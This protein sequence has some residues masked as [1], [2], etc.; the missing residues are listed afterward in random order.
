MDNFEIIVLLISV[1]TL[2]VGVAQK[3]HIPYPIALVIG[4]LAIG[5]IPR[6]EGFTVDPYLIL[7]IVLP[8]ILYYGAYQLPFREFIQNWKD[9]FSLAL[10]LVIVTT[11]VVGVVV[12]W[13]IP[14]FSWPL[15]FALGAI[16]S[17]PDAIA[18]TSILRRFAISNHT[19]TILE[20]ESLVNDASALVFYRIAVFAI[21]SGTFSLLDA[22]ISFVIMSTGGV[23]VGVITGL[24]MQYFS[25]RYLAPVVGVLFSFTIPYSTYFLA[26][27]LGLSGVLAV[28]V[29]GLIGARMLVVHPSPQR[30]VF[31]ITVWDVFIIMLNCFVF[32]LIGMQLGAVTKYMSYMRL[33]EYFL[34]GCAITLV[35]IVVRFIWVYLNRAIAYWYTKYYR[36]R[37][38]PH[39]HL[40]L[41]EA[42]VIGWSGM[43]GIVSLVAA[44]GLPLAH[45]NGMP[46]VHRHEAVYITFIVIMLTLLLPGLTLPQLLHF[47]NIRHLSDTESAS[48]VRQI[49]VSAAEEE[50]DRLHD[51]QAISD[52]EVSIL[53]SYI[54]ARHRVMDSYS[55][56]GPHNSLELARIKV[57]GAQRQ[58]LIELWRNAEV[59]DRLIRRME[60]ELD[61]EESYATRAEIT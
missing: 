12:K 59:D 19:L 26:D 47:L 41:R 38:C 13:L 55:L 7:V 6:L 27:S 49:L 22:S 39:A 58:K 5:F 20:G 50:I 24:V 35:M 9:I 51:Q 48:K 33:A 11:L 54:K 28:V 15:A 30:R 44:L 52:D 10:G 61:V 56:T 60:R 17:P 32:V 8:P 14:D 21:F 40:M 45:A 23:A 1:S 18:S 42:T 57:I 4:G 37:S 53:T 31:G 25:H 3:L 29:N 34:D 46:L 36:K 43:R 2:L 16:V